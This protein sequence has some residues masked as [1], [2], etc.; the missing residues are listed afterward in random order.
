MWNIVQTAIEIFNSWIVVRLRWLF[1]QCL[2]RILQGNKIEGFPMRVLPISPQPC[3]IPRVLPL[4][5]YLIEFSHYGHI[6][7]MF[8][9]FF[10]FDYG[11]IE[12]IVSLQHLLL[13]GHEYLNQYLFQ[14]RAI[15]L[16]FQLCRVIRYL[17]G[18]TLVLNLAPLHLSLRILKQRYGYLYMSLQFLSQCLQLHLNFL[19]SISNVSNP[20]NTVLYHLT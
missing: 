9:V 18:K 14:L 7:G 19:Q 16:F 10:L 12:P 2:N 5:E 1:L 20:R 13:N 17:I 8:N 4:E 15:D 11:H 6:H 3:L